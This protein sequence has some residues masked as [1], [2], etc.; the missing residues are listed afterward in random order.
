MT[1]PEQQRKLYEFMFPEL[2]GRKWKFVEDG[3]GNLHGTWVTGRGRNAHRHYIDLPRLYNPDGTPCVDMFLKYG[4]PKLLEQGYEVNFYSN[5]GWG[6]G[7]DN[8]WYWDSAD[9]WAAT[10]E[11][12]EAR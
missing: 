1:T 4:E 12:L 9:P 3:D 7:F 2:E 5:V 11:Y 6:I 10:V 8:R